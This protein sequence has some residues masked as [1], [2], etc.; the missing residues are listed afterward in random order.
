MDVISSKIVKARKRHKC[1]LCLCNIEVGE[2]YNTQFNKQ[3]GD[4]YTFK[5]HIHCQEIA[6]ELKMYDYCD[7]GLNDE[8]FYE[9]I[10]EEFIKLMEQHNSQI[11][12]YEH[13]KYPPFPNQLQYVCEFYKIEL[14]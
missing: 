4:T 14:P 13:Y 11:F 7:Y 6:S 8:G 12:N 9:S 1:E 2:K 10:K 5:N 3:D